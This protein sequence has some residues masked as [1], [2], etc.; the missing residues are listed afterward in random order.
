MTAGFQNTKDTAGVFALLWQLHHVFRDNVFS[1]RTDQN[2][3][4]SGY[5]NKEPSGLVSCKQS[6]LKTNVL[7]Q[8]KGDSQLQLES[9]QFQ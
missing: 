3:P 5:V 4:K 2:P 6:K 7:N 1:Q 9:F 8:L